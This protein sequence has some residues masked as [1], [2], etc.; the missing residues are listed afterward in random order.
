MTPNFAA[1][2]PA[3]GAICSGAF[4]RIA[5][6]PDPRLRT[7]DAGQAAAR[8][9]LVVDLETGV[10]EADRRFHRHV[11]SERVGLR[12]RARVRTSG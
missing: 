5:H 11:V 2:R 1:P 10:A 3:S 8:L 7:F 9:M 6:H 12:N 4:G